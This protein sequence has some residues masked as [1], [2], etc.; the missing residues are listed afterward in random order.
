MVPD[1]TV[2]LVCDPSAGSIAEGIL[3]FLALGGAYFEPGIRAQ[4]RLYGWDRLVESIER[5]AGG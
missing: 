1:G 2:G 4:K 3:R 5:L